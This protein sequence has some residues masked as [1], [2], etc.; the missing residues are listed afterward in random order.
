LVLAV[1]WSA[2]K[3]F[4]YQFTDTDHQA[5]FGLCLLIGLR[6]TSFNLLRQVMQKIFRQAT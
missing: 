4:S 6:L 1:T 5:L 3:F 2:I